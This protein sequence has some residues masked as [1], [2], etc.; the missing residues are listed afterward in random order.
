M[1]CGLWAINSICF[2]HF[3]YLGT[4]ATEATWVVWAVRA[5]WAALAGSLL[6][7]L[8]RLDHMGNLGHLRFEFRLGAQYS[9]P[10][11]LHKHGRPEQACLHDN[12]STG[13]M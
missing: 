6:G 10:A 9:K 5:A 12:A 8:G 1:P 7:R 2:G 4:W 3:R 11:G 13:G